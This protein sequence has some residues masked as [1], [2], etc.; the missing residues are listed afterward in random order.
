M[1]ADPRNEREERG[2][3]EG[4]P[5]SGRRGAGK[6]TAAA[7]ASTLIG[8]VAAMVIAVVANVYVARHY[9]RWD[10]SRGGLY[11]LSEPTLETLH[12]LEEPIQVYVMLPSGDPLTTSVLHL[13][14]AYK[15]ETSRLVVE[16]T[17]PDRYPA[18]FLAIQQKYGVA[19]GKTED[20][21]ILTDAAIIVARRDKPYF[22]T[23]NDLVAV[24]DEE[25]PRVRPRLEEALTTAIRAVTS[26][27]KPK[28]C[29][30]TGH[31]EK[32]I[33]VGG[34]AGVAALKDRLGKNNYDIVE[35]APARAGEKEELPS[36][37]LLVIAGPTEPVATDD[38]ARYVG[39]VKSGG[40]V[41]MAVS[42][43][44][45]P[46][47]G[48]YV[49]LRLGD[50][51]ASLGLKMEGDFVF[52]LDP[53][54]RD[55]DGFG[56]TFLPEVKPHAIT[57]GLIKAA[58]RGIGVTLTVAASISKVPSEASASPL[59]ATSET[60]FGMVDFFAWAKN[61]SQPAAKDEDHKGPLSVA[62]AVELPKPAGAQA[63]R[64]G[65]AVVVGS[66]G[67]ILSTNWQ[68]EDLRGTAAFVESSVSWLVS[69]PALVSLP[70]KPAVAAGLR[71]SEADVKRLGLYTI[72]CMP[73][74]T[75][76]FGVA[77][78]LRRKSG[79]RR[80]KKALAEPSDRD[81]AKPAKS[82]P[83]KSEKEESDTKSA[84]AP[85]KKKKVKSSREGGA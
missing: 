60:S 20:G 34:G 15:A 27:K 63:P 35:I 53:K 38:V 26:G 1:S 76:L 79:E 68:S 3:R 13:L 19:A 36:C 45:D 74:A 14:E 2:E 77:V 21:R 57:E 58:D 4:G 43:V 61:P 17:D 71:I 83:V 78:F 31:G 48:R 84:A 7:Q 28:V 47:G 52:E 24:E 6:T 56:E 80:G 46:E 23:A 33:E 69:R 85:K 16:K 62:W 44:P 51:F 82:E 9:K 12:S 32:S 11:T 29:F 72:V 8:I 75:I 81:E 66:S 40:S 67:P 30:A 59:L 50:L 25:D 22:L 64:G 49:D 70:R 5:D 39:Y 55:P 54:R 42:P 65:R 73:L 37:D 41:L 18:E 10:V